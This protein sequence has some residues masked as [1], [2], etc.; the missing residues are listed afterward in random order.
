MYRAGSIRVCVFLREEERGEERVEKEKQVIAIDGPVGAGKST[1]ARLLAHRLGLLYIDTGAM[2]RALAWLVRKRGIDPTDQ[3]AVEALSARCRLRF[4]QG[5]E[6]CLW[7][8]EECLSMLQLRTEDLGQLA[9]QISV[10]PGVRE[11]LVRKQREM[12]LEAGGVV[13]EG[14]DIGTVVLPEAPIKFYLEASVEERARRKYEQLRQAGK[15]VDL[16]TISAE[17]QARDQRDRSRA[18]SPLRAAPD[19]IRIDT[20]KLTIDEA[21]HLMLE[22]VRSCGRQDG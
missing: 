10:Y 22:Q 21:L 18:L 1:L 9:S 13:M 20:T 16:A 6:T 15:A 8:E 19:A 5:E 14:R 2:Y 11:A 12:A 7:V 3:E 17:I 4:V